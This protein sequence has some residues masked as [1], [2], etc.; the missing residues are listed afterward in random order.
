VSIR[1]LVEIEDKNKERHYR[2][3]YNLKNFEHRISHQRKKRREH[4][5]S[6]ESYFKDKTECEVCGR[7]IKFNSGNRMTSIH[8]DHRHGGIAIIKGSPR[9]WLQHNKRTSENEEIWKSCD[10]GVLCNGCNRMLPTKNRKQW[11]EKYNNNINNYI[12]NI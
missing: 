10:F 1:E 7:S 12:G 6:W 5:D 8:F 3:E 9:N 2:Q 11:L 4:I